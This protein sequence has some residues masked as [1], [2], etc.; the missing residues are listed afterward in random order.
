MVVVVACVVMNDFPALGEGAVYDTRQSSNKSNGGIWD[1]HLYPPVTVF[2]NMLIRA[3][4]NRIHRCEGK[5]ICAYWCNALCFRCERVC[6]HGS[7]TRVRSCQFAVMSS[8]PDISGA[9]PCDGDCNGLDDNYEVK[10]QG[11]VRVSKCHL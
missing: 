2:G 3:M 8:S 7:L 11:E 9:R 5:R 10:G 4:R 1:V 6:M